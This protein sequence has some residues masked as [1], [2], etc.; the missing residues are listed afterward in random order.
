MQQLQRISQEERNQKALEF[1]RCSDSPSY[2]AKNYCQTINIETNEISCFPDYS[3]LT[4]FLDENKNPQN[5]H[6]EKSR[7]MLA[8]WAFMILFL[9]D[10]T[11]KRNIADF[12]TSRK[13][14]LVDDGG[15]L[16]TPNSL[17]G[18]IRFIWERLPSFLKMP[19]EFS[20]LKI[21]NS[22]TG[23]YIIGESSNPN[24]GRSGTW[25]RA[26]MDET[27]LI[28]KSESVFS[29]I[30]QACKKGTYMNS[31]P[32]G[33]GGC[34]A[35]IRFDKKTTFRKRSFHWRIHPLRNNKWYQEQ[36]SNMTPDQIA[37]ELDISYEKSVAGQIWFMFD[38]NTQVGDYPYNPDL[39]LFCGWDFGIGNPTAIL[40]IQLMPNPG[41]KFPWVHIIDECEENEK[42]PTYFA[43]VVKK[44]PY[45][46]MDRDSL[47][48]KL[49]DIEHYGDPAGKQRE[50]NMKSWISSLAELGIHIKV[51]HGM[52]TVDKIMAGQQLVPYIRVNRNCV[53]L[54]ECIS[55]YKHPT[56][57]QGMVIDDGYEK[58]W[59]THLMKAFEE[60]AVNEFPIRKTEVTVL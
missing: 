34:F 49:K 4:K 55:N 31:T 32:Y 43:D 18:R 2:F 48:P 13:E 46:I 3:Y 41:Q 38:F 28:P 9:H 1:I 35:R 52:R 44:K 14:F 17:M 59:A 50:I 57:D 22:Y 24:A 36:C 53:R 20:F 27:A 56:D 7:Q 11:F 51:R 42:M 16:S 15:S 40:W 5:V 33:R 60:F 39:P 54:Q 23:S 25:Y 6:L 26:V 30:I 29:S 21:R 47:K 10:I 37:R 8:S 12:I 58:N 19:L 45:T